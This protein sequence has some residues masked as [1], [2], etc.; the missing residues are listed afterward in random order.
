MLYVGTNVLCLCWN[1]C[2]MLY[3]GTNVLFFILEPMCYALCLNQCIMLYV[4]T[5][6]LCFTLEP[7][8][9]I[10]IAA[11]RSFNRTRFIMCYLYI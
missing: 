9:V 2:V 11:M 4:G 6:V 10:V 7:A 8:D 3:V 1:Q 5:N